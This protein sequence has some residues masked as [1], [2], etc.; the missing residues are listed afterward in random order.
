M[1]STLLTVALFVA[2]L[3]QGALADFAIS[4]P[5]L[6][7]CQSS[8]ISWSATTGPYNLIVVA[9]DQP[10]GDAL[11]DIGD[12][13]GT[14]TNWVAALPAGK[15]V[16]LSLVDAQD[17]EAWSKT[18]TIGASSDTSCLPAA[19]K[20]AGSSSTSKSTSGSPTPGVAAAAASSPSPSQSVVPVG[21]ANAGTNPFSSGASARQ[22]STPVMVLAAVAAA[23]AMSL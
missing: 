9:A 11:V 12:F 7:Q 17:N 6:V 21:A 5:A 1:Y 18:I 8:K 23:I 22:A 2:P 16:V 10:C 4:S 14:V 3:I 15:Q 13:D 19:L 20:P